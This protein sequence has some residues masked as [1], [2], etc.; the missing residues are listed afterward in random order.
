M[1]TAWSRRSFLAMTAA[2]AS[3]PAACSGDEPGTVAKDGSVT[4]THAFGETRIPAPPT[5]VVSAGLTEQDDLLAVGMVPIAVTDWF[6]GEPF[7]VWPWARSQLGPAQPTVLSLADGVQIEAI[8]GLNPDLIVATNAG[9]DADTY[10][11]LSE[12]APT[13]AQNGSAAFFEP[14]KDQATVIG[15]AVFK[16]DEMQ[17]AITRVDERFTNAATAN[18]QFAGKK[19]LLLRGPLYRDNVQAVPPGWR[20]DFLTQMGFTV[21]D[22]GDPLIP[23]DRMASVLDAADVLIWTTESDQEQGAILADPTIAGLKAVAGGRTI[24]TDKELAG[25]IAFASPLSYPLV[26]DRLPPL[27]AQILA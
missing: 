23:R 27:L 19:A 20:T 3:A 22:P 9:L 16:A 24:F 17:T 11:T 26:A 2:A 18:P 6:G 15:Q 25:A 4:V 1:S 21:A 5:R 10:A 7:G 12:I 13:V 14:W 8:R